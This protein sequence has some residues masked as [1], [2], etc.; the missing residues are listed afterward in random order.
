MTMR[1]RDKETERRGD[2]EIEGQRDRERDWYNFCRFVASPLRGF[3]SPSLR[4]S[5][6]LSLRLSVSLSFFICLLAAPTREAQRQRPS[7]QE[8]KAKTEQDNKAQT[9]PISPH[10]ILITINGLRSDFVTGAESQR[11]NIPTIQALRS[12]GSC[13]VGVESV[14]PTQTLPAHASLITGSLPSDHWITSD[15]S[16]DQESASQSKEPRKSAKE[17][18]TETVFDVARREKLVVAAVG[19]PLTA[20]TAITFNQPDVA[21]DF[22]KA[23]SAADIIEKHRPSLLLVNFTS[24]DEAQRRRGLLSAESLKAMEAIDG[25]V[26]KIVDATESA[27][28]AEE[29][30]FILVS[31]S[32]ASKVEK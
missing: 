26:K 7:G 2:R 29:T 14:F 3:I 18:K 6:S 4:P 31:D 21:E 1:R 12:R 10:V 9:P 23:T 22:V 30:T 24:F 11:L 13:A 28:I 27:R 25:M 32:G 8:G 17:I 20:D 19:F 5:I 16:F 15:Y